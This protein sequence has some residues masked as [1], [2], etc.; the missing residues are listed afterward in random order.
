MAV[1]HKLVQE[2]ER[3]PPIEIIKLIDIVIRDII[4]PDYDIDRVWAQE[5]A[6]RWEA[7]KR[8]EVDVVSYEDVMSK[9][10]K[11]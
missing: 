8:G 6:S 9:Y 4:R 3:L 10:K 2:I 5:A 11:A 1:P 7:Y